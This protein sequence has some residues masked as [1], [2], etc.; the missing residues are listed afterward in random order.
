MG[1]TILLTPDEQVIDESV[2]IV[3]RLNDKTFE[4]IQGLSQE[5]FY[6]RYKNIVNI[7]P[8]AKPIRA[9]AQ[10]NGTKPSDVKRH[11]DR[12]ILPS[13]SQQTMMSAMI[14]YVLR[15]LVVDG[16]QIP[17]FRATKSGRLIPHKGL[18]LPEDIRDIPREYWASPTPVMGLKVDFNVKS[19]H[20]QRV[21]YTNLFLSQNPAFT[22]EYVELI[23]NWVYEMLGVNDDVDDVGFLGNDVDDLLAEFDGPPEYGERDGAVELPGSDGADG[24]D[25]ATGTSEF[26]A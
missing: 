20:E 15:T 17:A 6:S 19:V 13:R 23:E 10:R 25:G 3:V 26:P 24:P 16:K 11:I 14:A 9:I 8:R 12:D 7:S 18:G 22:E 2:E 1:D 21:A 4:Q 5:L